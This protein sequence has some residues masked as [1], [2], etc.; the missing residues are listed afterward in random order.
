[1]LQCKIRFVAKCRILIYS[2]LGGNFNHKNG[3]RGKSLTFCRSGLLGLGS[4]VWGP[5][6]KTLESS[7]GTLNRQFSRSRDRRIVVRDAKSSIFEVLG[8]KNRRPGR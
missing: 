4:R 3:G 7:S 5:G 2:L 8:P 6:S 1:M